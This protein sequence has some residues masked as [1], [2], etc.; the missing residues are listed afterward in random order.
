ME[1]VAIQFEFA[2]GRPSRFL[3]GG[4]GGN[5]FL[6]M[7]S[8]P[9]SLGLRNAMNAPTVTAAGA[10]MDLAAE[11]RSGIENLP[12]RAKLPSNGGDSRIPSSCSSA[13]ALT[14]PGL[15]LSVLRER[16]PRAARVSPGS[17]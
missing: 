6:G 2:A 3:V 16:Q 5:R 11:C 8:T 13:S 14:E 4:L 12:Q 1:K 15:P 9:A 10:P 7:R 17:G